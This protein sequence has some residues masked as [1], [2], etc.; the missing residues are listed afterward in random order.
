MPIVTETG[1]DL[2]GT[3]PLAG[4]AVVRD[5]VSPAEEARLIACIEAEELA[6]FRFQHWFGKR[7]TRSFGW[8]Y[9]FETGAFGPAEAIPGW[10]EPLRL[11][12]ARAVGQPAGA[13]EQV[14]LTRYD[15][16]AAIGWHRDR[17]VFADVIGVSLGAPATMRFRKR[18]GRG[19]RRISMPLPPRGL[20]RLSGEARQC[21][22]H[23]IA[24]LDR[25]RWSITF[26]TL[27]ARMSH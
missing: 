6:P 16:G 11:K 10:I 3:E 24:P 15:P 8:S 20:Y 9:D 1:A 25:P 23:S 27:A 22:E 17:P 13:L 19:F 5:I 12:A 7:Q 14:L 4:F 26:R 18:D 2:F 21:W